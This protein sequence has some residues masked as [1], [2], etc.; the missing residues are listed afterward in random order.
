MR[1]AAKASI[2]II[3]GL[4]VLC[5]AAPA[6]QWRTDDGV[7]VTLADVTGRIEGFAVGGHALK[8]AA[9][10][11]GGLSF[12]EFSRNPA[13]PERLVLRLG[14]EGQEQTWA[15]AA[16]AD[17]EN[18]GDY[19]KRLTGDAPEGEAYLRLGDGK[20]VGAGMAVAR[21]IPLPPGGDCTISWWARTHKTDLTYIICLR[22]FDRQGR[23]IT[24]TT[25]A[26]A[27][28]VYSP[29]SQAHYRSDLANNQADTW[30]RLSS[31]YV[32]PENA[33]SARLSLRVYRG[34]DL[35][36]DI[37]DLRVSVKSGGWSEEVAVSAKVVPTGGG[38]RQRA[39]LP[40]AGLAFETLY[41][42]EAGQLRAVVEVTPIGPQP[43]GRCLQLRY[44]LPLALEG[45]TWSAAPG[46][47]EVIAAGGHYE[48]G[49]G[50]AGHHLSRY[51]LAS[52]SRGAVGL[53]LA[54]PLD[55]PALQTFSA[56]SGGLV[57]TVDLGLSP[58]APRAR[59]RFAFSLYRHD[60]AWTFRAALERYYALFPTL[61]E[62]G[63]ERGG[64][65]TLRV[66][67]PPAATPEEFGLAYYECNT[68]T[69][70][71]R[72][73]CRAHGLL[74]FVYS[75]PWGRRQSFP[76]AKS[77]A[78]MPPY[79]QRLAALKQWAAEQGDGAKWNGAP[80]AEV[81]QAVLNSLL[82]GADGLGAHLVDLYSSW[83]QW[84]QLNTDPD[85][86]EP[87]IA[88]VCRKYE[89]EPALQWADG[90][91]LDSVSMTHAEFE[92]HAP[93]HLAAAD[94]PLGFSL[95][96][97]TPVVLSGF[98]DYE[99]MRSL[100]D[101]LHRRK[102]LLMLNLFPP[103]TRLY[104]HLGDVVGC[105]LAGPQ[106]D[107][108]ALQQRIYAF[109]RPVSNLLQWRWAVLERVPAMTSAEMED[110]L[111]NQLLYGFWPGIS[112]AGGG[113]EA[114]Y[115]YLH[116]YLED[117]S[118]LTRDRALFAR[119]LPAFDALNR[120]GWEPV[121]HARTE[122][123]E[124][125]A[126]RF[127]RGKGTLLAVANTSGQAREA[128][129]TLDRDWWERALGH[130]GAIA[131]DSKLTGETY[132]AEGAGESLSCRVSLPPH[133]TLVLAVAERSR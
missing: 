61:F 85:L 22:L 132:R 71:M 72:D 24:A 17:W 1:R 28:W 76:E 130:S 7:S 16:F 75:E 83:S 118:L 70:E 8:L 11:T 31:S 100:R 2:A 98:S 56:D 32:A 96:T 97:G 49:V 129:L 131:F 95:R 19:V 18:N 99:F 45:W 55:Q 48:A 93:G 101:D 52:V 9:G 53:G 25:P 4:L 109:R 91:Y 128:T 82:L 67:R 108:D 38:L 47:D 78:E 30:E 23:D 57:T 33:V 94:L 65:W 27:G 122:V 54:A 63:S 116:R 66:P 117:P 73:Y 126:E 14:A 106:G 103:A 79:E 69:Q 113:T 111:A 88:S 92:D 34:G 64:A 13:E 115:R 43:R 74:T 58:A 114:G 86:P 80:R 15:S 39:E 12:R 105:E 125:R 121:T 44:R 123:P 89:I 81:A 68:L 5:T 46:H 36:A 120:A 37:D 35:Q 133:R 104:G 112:T 62:G 60:P 51:P 6:A 119:Y 124:V 90:I 77:K 50:L 127:G 110:Y 87:N 84:W 29:Y 102:K 3:S 107:D 42:S 21:A 40:S 59:G 20:S 41:T 26:P 10:A